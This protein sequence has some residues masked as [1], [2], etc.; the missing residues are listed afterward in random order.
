VNATRLLAT[1]HTPSPRA[2]VEADAPPRVNLPGVRRSH[3][4]ARRT[5]VYT[6]EE[7]FTSTAH[8]AARTCGGVLR[9]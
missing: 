5:Q 3:A 9:F 8:W 2:A 1:S 6:V 7:F 4:N